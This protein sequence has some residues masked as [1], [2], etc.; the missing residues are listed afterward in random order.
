[1]PDWTAPLRQRLAGVRMTPAR[2]REVLEELSQHLDQRYAELLASGRS[3]DA[4]RAAA[5]EEMEAPEVLARAMEPLRQ[6]NL[7]RPLTP[8]APR[9]FIVRDIWQDLRYAGRVLRKQ[10]GF[11]A[12]AI[13]TLALGIGANS[14]MFA[15]VD[16]TLL[17]PLPL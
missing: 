17:R 12:A 7:P 2:E 11:A 16:A 13:L 4:A 5:M 6:A 3:A 9:R 15:L 1:M 8:G 14:A 10:P